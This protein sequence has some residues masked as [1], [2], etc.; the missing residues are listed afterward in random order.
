MLRRLCVIFGML[1]AFHV[2]DARE[3]QV[4]TPLSPQLQV[5]LIESQDEL[6]VVVPQGATAVGMQFGLIGALVGAGIQD[7]QAKSAEAKAIPLRD[8]LVEYRFNERL[9]AALRA[10]LASEGLSPDPTLT[11]RKSVWEAVDAEDAGS[12]PLEALVLTTAYSMDYTF[13]QLSVTLTAQ[14]AK[15]KIKSNGRIKTNYD[16][17]RNYG[18]HFPMRQGGLRVK[19]GN[20]TSL[21]KDR[22]VACM[23]E[24]IDQLVDML[25]YDFSPQGRALWHEKVGEK[26]FAW[27]DGLAFPGRQVRSGPHRTW[28]IVGRKWTSLQGYHPILV[29][30]DG[31]ALAE[32]QLAEPADPA[33]PAVPSDP[34]AGSAD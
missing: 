18:Y 25:A 34:V 30:A 6:A 29:G 2:A 28:A 5:E 32:P 11:V 1:V 13:G 16:F 15:R 21:G 19:D 26:E 9:E 22:L 27:V 3:P 12:V 24:A 10:R 33:D 14:H 23:D 8:L 17:F 4:P 20:W 31:I 7:H